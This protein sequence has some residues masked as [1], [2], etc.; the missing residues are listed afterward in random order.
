[1]YQGVPEFPMHFGPCQRAF[2]KDSSPS[3]LVGVATVNTYG[4]AG[5]TGATTTTTTITTTDTAMVT[6]RR[7]GRTTSRRSFDVT[8]SE[9]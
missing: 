5:G 7:T 8:G 6:R 4:S 1:M 2:L 3:F 9:Q